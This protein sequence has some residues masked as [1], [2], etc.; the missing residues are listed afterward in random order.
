MLEA[1][2]DGYLSK[3]ISSQIL[4]KS[5]D[6]S[7]AGETI[8]PHVFLKEII[9]A[10]NKGFEQRSRDFVSQPVVEH[11]PANAAKIRQEERD[12]KPLVS[13]MVH[14]LKPIVPPPPAS[15][16]E[17]QIARHEIARHQE[18]ELNAVGGNPL[19]G[20]RRR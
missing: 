8:I 12:Q 9:E 16:P 3:N 19:A 17:L 6:L 10:H 1:G 11:S 5:L 15:S 7:L 2:A 18:P 4:L 14:P 20:S 13:L